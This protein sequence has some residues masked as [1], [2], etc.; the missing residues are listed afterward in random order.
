MF[1]FVYE[2]VSTSTA[3]NFSIQP[4]RKKYVIFLFVLLVNGHPVFSQTLKSWLPSQ[5]ELAFPNEMVQKCFGIKKARGIITQ[6][7]TSGTERIEG[8]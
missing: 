3:P 7:E 5:Q 8:S 4:M 6:I 1:S 2:D